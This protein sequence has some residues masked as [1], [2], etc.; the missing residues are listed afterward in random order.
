MQKPDHEGGRNGQGDEC[1][2]LAY[3]RAFARETH[4]AVECSALAYARAFAMQKKLLTAN[5]SSAIN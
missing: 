4:N 5:K 1:F 3:A 2:A